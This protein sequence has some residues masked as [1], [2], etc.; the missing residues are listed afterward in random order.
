MVTKL[1]NSRK[2]ILLIR[3]RTVRLDSKGLDGCSQT[4]MDSGLAPYIC[5]GLFSPFRNDFVGSKR[6]KKEIKKDLIQGI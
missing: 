3:P 1:V 2:G 5:R 4:I 6:F